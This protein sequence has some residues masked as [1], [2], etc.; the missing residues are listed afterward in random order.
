MSG[1]QLADVTR[2]LY[3]EGFSHGRVAAFR[4]FVEP[5][6]VWHTPAG[7]L[8]S[9]ELREMLHSVPTCLPGIKVVIQ[10]EIAQADRIVSR[11]TITWRTS[12]G[13]LSAPVEGV[14]IDRCRDGRLVERWDHGDVVQL[15]SQLGL[16]GPATSSH[17]AYDEEAD[18]TTPTHVVDSVLKDSQT[19]AVVGM[20]TDET[21]YAY[22]IPTFLQAAGFTVIPIHPSAAEIAG[23]KAYPS[24]G[25]LPDPVDVVQV[26]RPAE[27]TPA[28]AAA[29][30]A[31][32][33]KALWLQKDIKSPQ[34]RHIA[35][36]GGLMYVEDHCMGVETAR[37]SI[38][39]TP[40]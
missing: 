25:Q 28:I 19:I 22:A 31:V 8:G 7:E 14:S 24:L 6:L 21:K 38:T 26:F 39:K 18:W 30:V 12:D 13:S 9:D 20:S 29:A 37:R 4:D 3:E 17:L 33:A 35:S 27:E 34:A 16:I 32:G 36:E 2:W 23:L 11:F 15:L 1:A 10:D 5:D 40:E